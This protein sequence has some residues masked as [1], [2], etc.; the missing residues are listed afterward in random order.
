VEFYVDDMVVKFDD[1]I[2]HLED[3]EEV[4]GQLQ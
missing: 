3:L 2:A 1:V 4:F